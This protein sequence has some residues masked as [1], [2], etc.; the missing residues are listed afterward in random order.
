MYASVG[1]PFDVLLVIMGFVMAMPE[2]S[3]PRATI[4]AMML[5]SRT[6]YHE[7]AKMLLSG[8]VTVIGGENEYAN[9]ISFVK[10][11]LA[12]DGIRTTYVRRLV[13]KR[14][15]GS[16]IPAEFPDLIQKLSNLTSLSLSPAESLL[17]NAMGEALLSAVASLTS[18]T[19]LELNRGGKPCQKLLRA[20][21]SPLRELVYTEDCEKTFTLSALSC[22]TQTL[23]VLQLQVARPRPGDDELEELITRFP[24]MSHLLLTLGSPY[25]PEPLVIG[26]YVLA[27]PNLKHLTTSVEYSPFNNRDIGFK[28]ARWRNTEEAGRPDRSPWTSLTELRSDVV[29]AWAFGLTCK[30]EHLRLDITNVY[31]VKDFLSDVLADLRPTTL[32]LHIALLDGLLVTR[33]TLESWKL[34]DYLAAAVKNHPPELETVDVG[35]TLGYDR[36]NAE[37]GYMLQGFAG[38]KVESFRVIVLGR[39]SGG[40]DSKPPETK[41]KD[42]MLGGLDPEGIVQRILGTI[43]SVR[44]AA[45]EVAGFPAHSA[46]NYLDSDS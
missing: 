32:Y 23:E 26:D 31:D 21:R 20:L 38:L 28:E 11:C 6:L 43:P 17:C 10:C 40:F 12:E 41:D 24:K 37:L 14:Y 2:G 4:A 42:K 27:F 9:S 19:R 7:G 8:D 5:A 46:R 1:M 16:E 30:V 25:T 3:H 44:R 34:R 29:T 35:V 39:M 36:P 13:F 22:C 45:F 15:Y 33:M 18:L